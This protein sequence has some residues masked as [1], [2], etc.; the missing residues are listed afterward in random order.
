VSPARLAVVGWSGAGKTYLLEALIPRLTAAGV[1]LGVLKHSSDL[2]PLHKPGSDTYRLSQT[3]AAWVAFSTP[4]GLQ[5]T[6][7]EL[8]EHAL[9]R[10][11]LLLVE[12]GK[13]SRGF[14]IEVVAPSSP[15]LPLHE[16]MTL[17]QVGEKIAAVPGVPVFRFEQMDALTSLIVAWL[18]AQ[19]ERPFQKL[20]QGATQRRAVIAASAG[21]SPR[22]PPP[23]IAIEAPLQ[24][25]VQGET[26]AMTM[27]TP[28]HDER[29]ALGFL[30]SEGILR[31]Q[32]D[33]GSVVH[34]GHP[35]D[36]SYGHVVDVTAAPGAML[37]LERVDA[38]RRGTLTTAAC[39][40]C[41]RQSI[42][43]L[44]RLCTPLQDQTV[45][46]MEAL[47]GV[48][49][50]LRERQALFSATGGTHAAAVLS[51]AGDVLFH[52][53]DVGRHNAVDKVVGA[54]VLAGHLRADASSVA[55]ILSVSG[56]ASFEIVQKA[57]MA[58]IPIVASVSAASSL[59]VDLAERANITLASFVRGEDFLI[60][61]HPRRVRGLE[62]GT[63]TRVK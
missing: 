28:G 18:K 50:A 32:E 25:R 11:D 46:D 21:S 13:S 7:R 48:G 17:A 29:L 49:G 45:V 60:Y 54:L 42:E 58:R 19:N 51:S 24:I 31:A 44:L 59:A 2:H 34:C 36:E 30:W 23:A 37:S 1:S 12:G 41:G 57:A 53:E 6:Q 4:E 63:E 16:G 43:D 61:T 3:G 26:V 15:P 55:C 27:R 35:G 39:G 9:P 62:L 52:H 10:C 5:L 47:R 40:V 8:S 56:R 22:S 14:R 20:S 38:A 33:V